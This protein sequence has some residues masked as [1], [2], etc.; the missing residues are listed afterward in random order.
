M[1]HFYKPLTAPRS[2]GKS[3]S[4]RLDSYRTLA[5]TSAGVLQTPNLE[6]GK[7]VVVKN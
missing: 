1:L 6:A 3:I 7:K 5:R 2:Y 4:K